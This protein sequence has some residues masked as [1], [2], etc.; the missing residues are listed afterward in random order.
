MFLFS[1]PEE[2]KKNKSGMDPI[3]YM[4]VVCIPEGW[5]KYNKIVIDKGSMTLG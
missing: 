4:E 5:T 2:I 3:M 1:E